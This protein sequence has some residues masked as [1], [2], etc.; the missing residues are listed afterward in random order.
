LIIPEGSIRSDNYKMHE[1]VYIREYRRIYSD[2]LNL[3][4]GIFYLYIH[5][6][7]NA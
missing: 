2:G 4:A 3:Y 5:I 1:H 7:F 6:V